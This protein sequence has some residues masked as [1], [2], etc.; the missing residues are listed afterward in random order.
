MVE[1]ICKINTDQGQGIHP[2]H[3]TEVLHEFWNLSSYVYASLIKLSV[4]V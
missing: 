2:Y 3:A 1:H 4:N